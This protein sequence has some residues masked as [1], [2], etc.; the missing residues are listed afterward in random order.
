MNI[1]IKSRISKYGEITEMFTEYG[2]KIDNIMILGLYEDLSS[3]GIEENRILVE[4][5]MKADYEK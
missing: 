3:I 5:S 2:E 4:F 1:Y